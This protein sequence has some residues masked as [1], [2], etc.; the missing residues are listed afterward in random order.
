MI[1]FKLPSLGADMDEGM[2]LEWRIGP[3]DTV[4]KGDIVAVVDTSK[5]AIDVESW[6]EGTV[7]ELLIEPGTTIPVGTPMALFLE[8]GES[9]G[10][11]RRPEPEKAPAAVPEAAVE[12]PAV[13][14]AAPPPRAPDRL[15]RI[16]PAARR[17][18][19]ELEV[20]VESVTGTGPGGAISIADIEQAAART[21]GGAAAR[22]PETVTRGAAPVSAAAPA[23]RAAAMRRTIGAAMAR[24]KREIPHY[25]LAETVDLSAANDWLRA[26]NERRPVTERLLIAALY[27]KAT[28]LAAKKYPELNGFFT[29]GEFR[30]SAAVHLGVA[31]SMRGGGLIAP[32][33]HD[34]DGKSLTDLMQALTDLVA[35][36]RAG[37]LRSSEIADPTLTVTS[38][39]EQSVETVHGVIYPPQ[40]ALVGFGRISERALAADGALRAAPAVTVSLAADHRVSDG[41]RGAVFLAEIRDLLQH[42][43]R[44]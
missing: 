3:G 43:E 23:D 35:R 5:A 15:Q 27:L 19:R 22:A 40:V 11:A 29:D 24:S 38:L 28:A 12:S 16:S 8:A 41:H 6:Q 21:D 13:A 4:R 18:A 37:S 10:E 30:P 9:P 31:I 25:Y 14:P 7:H 1:E 34:V 44:L 36:A 39:G 32:A 33:I 26:E 2:L 42:P 20:D 17:R